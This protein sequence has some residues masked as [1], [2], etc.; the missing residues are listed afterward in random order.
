MDEEQRKRR[1]IANFAYEL[2]EELLLSCAELVETDNRVKISVSKDPISQCEP[3]MERFVI[4][5]V[6]PASSAA[7]LK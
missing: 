1:K 6:R 5:I 4:E 2:A 7:E 3:G